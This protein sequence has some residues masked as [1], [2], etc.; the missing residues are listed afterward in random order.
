MNDRKEADF[1]GFLLRQTLRGRE[2]DAPASTGLLAGVRAAA[3]RRTRARRRL[4]IAG[5]AIAVLAIAASA[6]LLSS[7]TGEGQSVLPA[8]PRRAAAGPHDVVVNGMRAWSFH[9]LQVRAPQ[10][11]AINGLR[12]GTPVRDTVVLDPIT[13]PSC[14]LA[15]SPVVQT[16][17]LIAS[18]AVTL[19]PSHHPVT[20]SGQ[21][22]I[23]G[24]QRLS[25][26]LTRE[27]LVLPGIGAAA[28]AATTNPALAASIIASARIVKV[29]ANGCSSRV[30]T[31]RPASRPGRPGAAKQLVPGNP[32]QAA[33]CHYSGRLLA[34]SFLVPATKLG[35][36]TKRLNAL[37]PGLRRA[38]GA[39]SQ[40][41]LPGNDA[42]IL[43]FFYSS[44]PPL[45]V[46]LRIVGCG[47]LGAD[48][49]A[50]T[51]G[52]TFGFGSLFIGQI[53]GVFSPGF[54]SPAH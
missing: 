16:L 36:L 8:G 4:A 30:S 9:G 34:H 14:L 19:P 31:L 43:R 28:E 10:A 22:G 27:V 32:T 15:P 26:G 33:V 52:L 23:V 39:A 37:K 40:C 44:G 38:Q 6:T 1:L 51:G 21:R 5:G 42:Y 47:D 18:Q 24:T 17:T 25:S 29:D 48:N 7:L 49:G 53:D 20:V 50:R 45:D 12:C 41:S 3:E 54:S 11:W 46:V 2:A 13:I 35:V